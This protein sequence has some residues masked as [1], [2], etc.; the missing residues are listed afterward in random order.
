MSKCSKFTTKI[1]MCG[2]NVGG[3][4]L[5]GVIFIGRISYY[6]NEFY[7]NRISNL[8]KPHFSDDSGHYKLN[9][10]QKTYTHN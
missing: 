1:K 8:L 9:F 5:K 7:K 4:I 2:V 6:I 3:S 10:H